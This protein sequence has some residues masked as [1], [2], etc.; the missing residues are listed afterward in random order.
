M[1]L[2]DSAIDTIFGALVLIL[3]C[4]ACSGI[5][6][7]IGDRGDTNANEAVRELE[8]RFD[9]C[10]LSTIFV[11][12]KVMNTTI[13]ENIQLIDYLALRNH[14]ARGEWDLNPETTEKNRIIELFDFYFG[15]SNYWRL[16][17]IIDHDT[18][19]PIVESGTRSS[20]SD[21]AVLERSVQMSG[22]SSCMISFSIEL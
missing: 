4:F 19:I 10:L 6:L 20:G 15:W 14:P 12:R 16:E 8:E 2:D 1:R 13:R 17:I 5:I 3:S 22:D 9:I 21:L 18:V 7:T 11:D